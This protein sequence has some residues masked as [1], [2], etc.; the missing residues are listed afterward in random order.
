MPAHKKAKPRA[1][2][3]S[4]PAQTTAE[5]E[6]DERAVDTEESVKTPAPE[7]FPIVGIGASA[8]HKNI[9]SDYPAGTSYQG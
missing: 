8:A 2:K 9:K 5:P 6:T 3:T 4:A 7:S 1:T